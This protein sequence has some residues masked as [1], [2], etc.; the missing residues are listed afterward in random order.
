MSRRRCYLLCR[1]RVGVFFDFTDYE[2]DQGFDFKNTCA[3]RILTLDGK[4]PRVRE[5]GITDEIMI[6]PPIKPSNI[7]VR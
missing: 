5:S 7:I 6:V 3:L 4:E 1:N 2:L